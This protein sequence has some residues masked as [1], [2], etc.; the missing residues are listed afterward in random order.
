MNNR[1]VCSIAGLLGTGCLLIGL[2]ALWAQRPDRPRIVQ[3]QPQPP[4]MHGPMMMGPHA[5]RFVA[6]HATEKRIVVLD[7]AT[8]KL[9]QAKESDLLPISSLP[10]FD[11]PPPPPPGDERGRPRRERKDD[12]DRPRERE[13]DRAP[14]N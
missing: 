14:R 3:S 7:S 6:A 1:T 2:G 8:G 10:K 12:N 9:Y 5:A 4:F 13:G 11:Q